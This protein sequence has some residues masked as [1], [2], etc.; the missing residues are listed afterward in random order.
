MFKPILIAGNLDY[1][2][3]HPSFA[4]FLNRFCYTANIIFM[5][6]P[7]YSTDSIKFLTTLKKDLRLKQPIIIVK[8]INNNRFYYCDKILTWYNYD[9]TKKYHDG[10]FY[11]CK[12][13]I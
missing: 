13:I 11:K 7:K 4:W 3:D 2:K 1:L 5:T 9:N 10:T 6:E 12:K 8:S